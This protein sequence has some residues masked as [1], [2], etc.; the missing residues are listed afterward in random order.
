MDVNKNLCVYGP[1][2]SST[3]HGL[4]FSLL[5]G[6]GMHNAGSLLPKVVDAGIRVLIYAGQADSSRFPLPPSL[7][8]ELIQP[9]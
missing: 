9:T 6:D 2:L 7:C 1:H 4:H 8:S 3:T 5:Q